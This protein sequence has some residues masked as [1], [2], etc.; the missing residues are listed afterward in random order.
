MCWWQRRQD[1]GCEGAPRFRGGGSLLSP[2][3][4]ETSSWWTYGFLEAPRLPCAP[5]LRQSYGRDMDFTR[6][7]LWGQLSS[8]GLVRVSRTQPGPRCEREGNLP[9][10]WHAWYKMKYMVYLCLVGPPRLLSATRG[11]SIQTCAHQRYLGTFCWYLQREFGILTSFEDLNPLTWFLFTAS[12]GRW[13]RPAQR[14][15]TTCAIGPCNCGKFHQTS[16]KC[17]FRYCSR[18]LV[19]L[20]GTQFY[21]HL[22]V[23]KFTNLFSAISGLIYICIQNLLPLWLQSKLLNYSQSV[24]KKQHLPKL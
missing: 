9:S 19:R 18:V 13:L 14:S 1:G 24:M 22:F 15:D 20:A 6:G 16:Y 21:R 5:V 11:E 3:L 7:H 4:K 17:F 8:W 10:S 2:A 12:S 23:S